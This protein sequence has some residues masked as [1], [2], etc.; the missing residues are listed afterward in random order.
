MS[1]LLKSILSVF[2]AVFMVASLVAIPSSAAAALSKT[3][4]S[5]T[6]GY[7]TTLSVSGASGTVSW[8]TGD[9]SIATVSSA[10][11]VVGKG[12]GTTYIYAKT[13]STTLKCK[14]TV[15]AAKISASTS[16]VQ[17]DKAGDTKTITVQV[18]GSHSGLTVGSLNKSVASA[19]WVKPVKWDGDK[20][21]LTLTAKGQGSTR[22]KVYL[23]NYSSTC[24]KYIDVN[25]GDY[26]VDDDVDDGSADSS[27]TIILANTPTVSVAAGE[28]YTLQVYSSNQDVLAFSLSNT[29]T[30]TVT[31]NKNTGN[32]RDYTIKGVAAGTVTLR[33][34]DKNNTKKY[35][36]VTIT[37]TNDV[38]YYEIYTE[39][40]AKLLTTD[41]II[42]VPVNSTTTYYMLV[43]V[44]YDP[45]RSNTLFAQKLNKFSYYEVYD[46]Q[47]GRNA[48]G[49]TYKQF[50]HSNRKYNYGSRYILIPAN[51]DEV[52][53]N[54]AVAKYNEYYE[55]YTIYNEK[56]VVNDSWDTIIPWT[57][58]D[59][60][61]GATV[62]R[63]MLVPDRYDQDRVN[64]IINKD[65]EVNS[66][67][68]YYTPYLMDSVSSTPKVDNSKEICLRYY[69]SKDNKEYFMIIP[70]SSA[71]SDIIKANNIV[72]QATGVFEYN[73]FYSGTSKPTAGEGESVAEYVN[74]S[75]TYY[76]LYKTSVG[77][78]AAYNIARTNYANGIKDD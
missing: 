3:S 41:T 5:L 51:Y 39:R 76:L 34:Y 66:T 50:T 26:P 33:I 40:P 12:V 32:Y 23:K 72:Q 49:D 13:G 22:I 20:V 8:S 28:T 57:V 70:K 27:S 25:V 71:L 16:S 73:V 44:G 52:K 9:K 18:K 31:A 69:N 48:S 2:L 45:A 63:Y 67:Y 61:T 68:N 21:K 55:Y 30:V 17:F 53:I 4:I 74:G 46:A 60:S 19:S 59:A 10:G 62:T 47:P 7:Q 75:T 77:E 35:S 24:Y 58:K 6:K 56:P 78:S 14:V 42:G 11:K 37:V 64:E 65:K 15:V 29:G 38:K 43:P 1:K 54:T 36:D